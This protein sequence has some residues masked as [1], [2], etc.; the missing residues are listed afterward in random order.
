M[1]V[2][3]SSNKEDTMAKRKSKSPDVFWILEKAT[4]IALLSYFIYKV[5]G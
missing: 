3:P 5:V 4:I 1:K 2:R